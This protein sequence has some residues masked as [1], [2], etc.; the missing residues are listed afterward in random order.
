[1]SHVGSAG[2]CVI[3]Q[4]GNRRNLAIDVKAVT[5]PTEAQTVDILKRRNMLLR[6]IR[7]FRKLQRAYMPNVR[8]FLTASQRAM[9]DSETERDAE[10]VRL[11]MPSDILDN[12][13]RVKACA[14]GLPDI[15]S[16]L[17]T[18]EARE[19]LHALRQALRARTMTN[20]FRLRHCTGQRMLTRGQ[21]VLRQIN[22]KIHKAK[23]RYRYARNA[24]MRLKSHGPWEKELRVLEDSD[25][26]ALNERAL[27]A[28][29]AE[30]RKSIHDYEDIAEEGGVAAFGVV[31]LGES[32]RTLS[33]IWYTAKSAEPTEAELVEGARAEQCLITLSLT[34]LQH[35]AWNGAKLTC[36][37]DAGGKMLFL[38]R[39]K[40]AVPLSTATGLRVSG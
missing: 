7:A 20:R 11:F 36:E 3:N 5:N 21:G 34:G 28:E 18:G 14:V 13:K 32:R 8:R 24:L 4:V 29:E 39:R 26:R 38:S 12:V 35:S 6:R 31:A 40:C 2:E 23:L 9:W 33:W 30:Q 16:D 22:L 17:Q 27:T 10:A 1:M 37:C 25:V 15:E 19:A